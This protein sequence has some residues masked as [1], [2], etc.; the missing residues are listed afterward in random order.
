MK[1]TI[2][3]TRIYRTEDLKAGDVIYIRETRQMKLN[4]ARAIKFPEC[5]FHRLTVVREVSK[6]K[7]G[8]VVYHHQC[9]D[10]L[11]STNGDHKIVNDLLERNVILT[12]GT[13]GC[14]ATID[15]HREVYRLDN[16]TN[17]RPQWQPVN[18]YKNPGYDLVNI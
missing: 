11:N 16:V 2:A 15:E 1:P 12:N 13:Y 9:H 18:L 4:A 7:D 6:L 8:T 10:F 3:K 5:N 17:T 14:N